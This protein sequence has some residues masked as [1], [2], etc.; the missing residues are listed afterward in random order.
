MSTQEVKNESVK[1]GE[2]PSRK[3][4]QEAEAKPNKLFSTNKV[5]FQ[6]GVPVLLE[7]CKVVQRSDESFEDKG[8]M[9]QPH[10]LRCQRTGFVSEVPA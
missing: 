2:Y 6:P 4:H 1:N 8:E 5:C 7:I 9:P 3:S 10:C